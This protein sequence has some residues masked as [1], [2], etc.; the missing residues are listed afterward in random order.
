MVEPQTEGRRRRS[1][2]RT[3]TAF[4]ISR[5]H[6]AVRS[7]RPVRD[8]SASAER[9]SCPGRKRG[10]LFVEVAF[11]Q[12]ILRKAQLRCRVGPVGVLEVCLRGAHMLGVG[13]AASG[14]ARV[15]LRSA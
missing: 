2:L 8:E 1:T 13:G 5:I 6:H 4:G 12:C 11:A 10:L 7:P 15:H 14:P 3:G 9:K